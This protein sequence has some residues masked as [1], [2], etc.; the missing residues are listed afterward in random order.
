MALAHHVVRT[1]DDPRT[2]LGAYISCGEQLF[3][4][5]AVAGDEG[6]VLEDCLTL[7]PHVVGVDHVREQ[8]RLE[9]AAPAS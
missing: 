3:Y 4:V 7:R 8:C 6:L 2:R 9:R 5:I 1:S